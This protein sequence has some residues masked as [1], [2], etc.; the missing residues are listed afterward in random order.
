MSLE[1]DA[2]ETQRRILRAL[3]AETQGSTRRYEKELEIFAEAFSHTCGHNRLERIGLRWSGALTPAQSRVLSTDRK[4]ATGFAS[5]LHRALMQH[6]LPTDE[7]LATLPRMA[8]SEWAAALRMGVQGV[9]RRRA[10][11]SGA[12]TGAH[13]FALPDEKFLLSIQPA[14]RRAADEFFLARSE[15]P[16]SV[17]RRPVIVR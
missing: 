12:G 2:E 3:I 7:E 13:D 11:L 4:A 17:E 1:A 9:L 6:L 8:L 14:V 15:M 5:C 10:F 16:D